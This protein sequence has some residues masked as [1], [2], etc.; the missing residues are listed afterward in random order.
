MLLF[1]VEKTE[2]PFFVFPYFLGI[3]HCWEGHIC[4]QW[5]LANVGTDSG[6]SPMQ[7]GTYPFSG[8]LQN[9][10]W[11]KRYFHEWVFENKTLSFFGV[12]WTV[13]EIRQFKH[14]TLTQMVITLEFSLPN[15]W[16]ADLRRT[17][18]LG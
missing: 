4:V 3:A 18:T 9:M 8:A 13:C 11:G 7:G 16:K 10:D 1:S 17:Q 2:F 12:R 5:I 14:Q 6:L 15:V